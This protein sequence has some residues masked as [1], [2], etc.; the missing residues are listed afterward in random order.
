[1]VVHGWLGH[2]LLLTGQRPVSGRTPGG[3]VALTGRLLPG[4]GDELDICRNLS[5]RLLLIQELERRKGHRP[6]NAFHT[7]VIAESLNPALPADTTVAAVM[8]E[9]GREFDGGYA[10]Y[11]LLPD[12]LLIPVSAGLDWPVLGA[13][14]ETYLTAWGAMQA[15]GIPG[16]GRPSDG[17]VYRGERLARREARKITRL[18]GLDAE[19]RPA[20]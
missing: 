2:F 20:A 9:M 6:E 7:Q 17:L 16:H 15:F 19:A 8:G 11:A 4:L 1:M 14:P 10:E 5:K 13:L 3:E 18:L 12:D